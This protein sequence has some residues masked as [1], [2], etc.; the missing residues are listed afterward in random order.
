[1]VGATAERELL[2][3]IGLADGCF[4]LGRSV[5]PVR[6]IEE[7]RR[8]RVV[9]YPTQTM[10]L[11]PADSV[12]D[13]PGSLLGD[14]RLVLLDLASRRL[15]TRRYLDRPLPRRGR[16]LAFAKVGDRRFDRVYQAAVNDVDIVGGLHRAP[17]LPA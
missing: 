16:T 10:V 4:E 14:P 3:G 5:A 12:S 9:S 17:P 13:I 7:Q 8:M 6:A 1:M 2:S 11:R 15:L